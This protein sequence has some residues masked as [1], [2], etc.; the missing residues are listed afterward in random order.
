MNLATVETTLSAYSAV[1]ETYLVDVWG[2]SVE[3]LGYLGLGV[4]EGLPFALK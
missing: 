4:S 1:N 3:C 2:V